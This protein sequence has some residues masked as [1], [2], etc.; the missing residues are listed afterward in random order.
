L[1]NWRFAKEM[2]AKLN[3]ARE[4]ARETIRIGAQPDRVRRG[5]WT[6]EEESAS[7]TDRIARPVLR[8]RSDQPGDDRAR[9][10]ELPP[11][12]PGVADKLPVA[13]LP[14]IDSDP[15]RRSSKSQEVASGD[16][17][18]LS[19]YREALG[20]VRTRQFAQAQESLIAFLVKF[21]NHAYSDKALYWLG[22]VFYAK[23]EYQR[24][25]EQFEAL[26]ARFSSS[27]KMPDALLKIGMCYRRLGDVDKARGFFRRVNSQYPK[28]DAARIALREG[29][30]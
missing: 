4:L 6:A 13:P 8:L 26:S 7:K 29:S 23:R 28:S 30:T 15:P 10:L 17:V 19:A 5:E 9:R 27:E 1:Q 16:N 21:P 14:D 2:R 12:P 20:L 24:A 11:P 18:E 25:L 22:E 3:P